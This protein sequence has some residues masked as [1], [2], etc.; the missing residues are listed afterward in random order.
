MTFKVGPLRSLQIKCLGRVEAK[1]RVQ[2]ITAFQPCPGL[3]N[4]RKSL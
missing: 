2:L 4:H 1:A 3:H